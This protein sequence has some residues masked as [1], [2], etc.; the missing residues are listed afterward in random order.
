[1][2]QSITLVL[3]IF[4]VLCINIKKKNCFGLV[5]LVFGASFFG[6]SCCIS[7]HLGML[8]CR[9]IPCYSFWGNHS[10]RLG[11]TKQEGPLFPHLYDGVSQVLTFAQTVMYSFTFLLIAQQPRAGCL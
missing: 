2:Y 11:G 9:K 5:A 4:Y 8:S 6:I 10:Y 1:M 3:T 7:G